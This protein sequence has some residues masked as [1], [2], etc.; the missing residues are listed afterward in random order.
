MAKKSQYKPEQIAEVLEE[1]LQEFND[2]D[3]ETTPTV[4]WAFQTFRDTT[5]R[6]APRWAITRIRS[7]LENGFDQRFISRAFDIAGDKFRGLDANGEAIFS[8][9]C[10]VMRNW[11]RD[12]ISRLRS[13]L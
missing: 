13:E 2:E 4:K 3:E 5:G 1:M 9:S 10:G 7:W 12:A 6:E 8:Y 11:K